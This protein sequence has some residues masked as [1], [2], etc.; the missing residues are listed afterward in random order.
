MATR[1]IETETGVRPGL[2]SPI[3]LAWMPR[4]L[5]VAAS[6]SLDLIRAVATCAVM[7]GHLRTLFFVDLGHLSHR[8]WP[9]EALYFFS[10]F[11]HQAVIVFFVLSGFLISST[12]IRSRVLGRWSWRDYAI[13]R[14]TRLYVVLVPGL[15]LGFFWDRMGSWL[16]AAR[17]IY[18]HSLSDLGPAVP[19]K[20]LTFGTLLGNLLF[21]QT[22]LCQSFGSNGPLWSLANEFW[23]YVLFP[24]SLGAG[25]A[26]AVRRF[27]VAIPLT[28]LAVLIGIFVGWG[29]MI[30]FLIWLAGCGLVFLYSKVQVRSRSVALGMLCFF[31][32]LAGISLAVARNRQWDPLLSDLE[33]GFVFALFLFALLQFQVRENSS[34][35]SAV[36]H[37]FAGFSYSLYVLH[38]PFLLFFR[39]WLVPSERWQPTP[40]H[41]L[42]ATS[43]GAASLLFAWLVSLVTEAKTDAA[44]KWVNRLIT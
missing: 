24:V 31:S 20:N 36:A 39:S 27:R 34:P 4:K 38:F 26:L 15:L 37:R 23:Y 21:L 22:I 28:C 11:G 25:L 16:F 12:V 5:S 6:D 29:I 2:P 10:G 18:A 30:G 3:S 9:L 43:V 42:A 8:S 33:L 41:L 19:L 35:F 44:R 17:G 40:T 1:T 7:I 32:I 14:A 13:N